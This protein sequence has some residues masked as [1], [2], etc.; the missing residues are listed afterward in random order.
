MRGASARVRPWVAVGAAPV[1]PL[2][3][4]HGR[5]LDRPPD[6]PQQHRDRD[7]QH[8]RDPEDSPEAS[9]HRRH[10]TRK[11]TQ[12]RPVRPKGRLSL[13]RRRYRLIVGGFPKLHTREDDQ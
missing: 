3:L 2:D 9:T 5:V 8:N 4:G 6:D 1:A 11:S 13:D 12:H 10:R 7:L